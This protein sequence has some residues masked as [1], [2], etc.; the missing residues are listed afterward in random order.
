MIKNNSI[1]LNV[2]K[3]LCALFLFIILSVTASQCFAE[4]KTSEKKNT[5]RQYSDMMSSLFYFIQQNYVDEVDPEVLYE[6]AIR[7]MLESLDDPYSSYLDK[8]EWRSLTD[9]TVGNFGGVGLQIT[10]PYEST[11]EKPAYVEVAQ[12]IENSP[13][14]KAGIISGDLIIKIEDV[15]TS[16]ISMEEV[17]GMLRGTVGEDVKVTI[18]R[19]KTLEFERVL[20]RAVIENPTVKYGMIENTKTGYIRISSFSA[21][22][23]KNVQD[24]LDS[25]KE[26]KYDSLIIDLRNNGGGLLSSA[27][28]I[29]DKFIDSGVIVSTKSRLKYEN[30]VYFASDKKTVVHNIPI[31][32]L[33]NGASASAS[34]ILSGA[35]KDTKTAY[36]VGQ[37]T[38]G[39]G[40]VQVPNSL[41]DSDGF[42]ITVARY[43]SPSDVNIDKKGIMPDEEVLFPE[44]SEEEEERLEKL[45]SSNVIEK[46]VEEH[47]EMSEKNIETYA[48]S[49]CKEYNLD[50][51]V[52]RKLIRNEVDRTKPSR[53]YD[54]DY[55]V[56]LKK[57]LEI[58][59][60]PDFAQKLSSVKTLKEM[61]EES[62]ESKK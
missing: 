54:M 9:T 8:A 36:L 15:D 2:Q 61:E 25:F 41:L 34:E 11:P 40:S 62:E 28:D 13:G 45:L 43:Y 22:T 10:K 29:A 4:S 27:V 26:N 47:A 56:Q 31:V 19:G 55:D 5:C 12:P 53:L 21:N 57:A 60:S 6:G 35:F 16:T 48:S 38:Y 30:S 3:A 24:A 18:R 46:Y 37:K 58:V 50:G 49:L 33:V 59:H 44:F 1:G 17:L 7:G 20:T 42:K 52:V 32:V 14:A 51:R 23:A 39:K